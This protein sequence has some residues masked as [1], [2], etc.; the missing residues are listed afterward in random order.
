MN[1]DLARQLEDAG[2]PHGDSG[3]RIADPTK[4]VARREDYAYVPT[5]EE[6]IEACGND[7]ISLNNR[8]GEYWSCSSRT[9]TDTQGKT[10]SE[11]VAHLWLA[12]NT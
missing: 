7:L 2:F 8:N 10:P 5:L 1:Y 9:F 12:N 4:L 11:A 6:L 3:K